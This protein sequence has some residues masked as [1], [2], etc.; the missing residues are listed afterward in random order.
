MTPLDTPI[1]ASGEELTLGLL[2]RTTLRG[3]T[4]LRY[5]DLDLPVT[6]AFLAETFTPAPG[7]RRGPITA[8][9]DL[10]IDTTWIRVPNVDLTIG[11]VT[12][13]V[14]HWAKVRAFHG[15][16][17][18]IYLHDERAAISG[19][20][21]AWTIEGFQASITEVE[22]SLESYIARLD[23]Q[24]PRMSYQVECN[25]ALGDRFCGVNL[26]IYEVMTTVVDSGLAFVEYGA[27]SPPTPP[28]P[29]TAY[30]DGWF[31]K[32]EIVFTSGNLIGFRG[33][34]ATH[35][36]STVVPIIPFPEAPDIGSEVSLF[37]G[38]LKRIVDCRD[39]FGTN[40]D[41]A[42]FN[43]FQRFLGF[44]YMEEMEKTIGFGG[45]SRASG[46]IVGGGVGGSG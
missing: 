33:T 14:A 8:G 26:P 32:G 19:Y 12:R 2:I 18:Q 9:I 36:G 43:W 15:A 31:D 4:I 35:I 42:P 3:G 38:C 37:P 10:Q 34:L 46:G 5:T 16:L 11:A 27:L 25:H 21:S 1:N 13:P 22:F 23:V 41:I 39:K 17:V 30:A 20:H 6:D 7:I 40:R 45:A 24:I 44:P 28:L 29:A